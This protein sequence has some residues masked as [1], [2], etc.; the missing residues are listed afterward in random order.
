[1]DTLNATIF[2][3]PAILIFNIGLAIALSLLIGLLLIR[4]IKPLVKG[5]CELANG[6]PVILKETGLL[7]D[8]SSSVNRTST[9]LQNKT[10][11]LKKQDQARANWIAGISHDI[12]TPL[13]MILGYSSE[14][15]END[16]LSNEE[17]E[18]SAI[19]KRQG[20]KLREL[21]ND[22]N[23]VSMLE[24]DMQPLHIEK[25]RPSSILRQVVSEL[26]NDGLDEKFEIELEMIDE[27]LLINGDERLLNRAI[28]NLLLNS[29]NHNDEGCHIWI[30][31]ER[32]SALNYCIITIRDDG[33]GIESSSIN[34]LLKLPYSTG[35]NYKGHGLGLPMVYRIIKAHNGT[36][37]L[38]S[39]SGKG[40]EVTISLPLYVNQ[41]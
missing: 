23:L 41:N 24:Y 29:I 22:L 32:N 15:E 9:E 21:V 28:T 20:I 1:M 7:R 35:K 16:I 19:I 27:S 30:K 12:R 39:S 36:L 2:W 4:S 3:V 31:L 17:R 25:I 18:K 11:A 34:D 37:L 10:T 8:I 38:S 14:L 5:I 33:E 6:R 40:F 13:S 26:L